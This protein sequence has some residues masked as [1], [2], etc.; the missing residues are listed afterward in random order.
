MKRQRVFQFSRNPACWSLHPSQGP[1][2]AMQSGHIPDVVLSRASAPVC[3]ALLFQR[4]QRLRSPQLPR[5]PAIPVTA[6]P[7]GLPVLGSPHR[8]RK[9][10]GNGIVLLVLFHDDQIVEGPQYHPRSLDG[11]RAGVRVISPILDGVRAGGQSQRRGVRAGNRKAALSCVQPTE[12]G[13]EAAHRWRPGPG[14]THGLHRGG[15][16]LA[17]PLVQ[18]PAEDDAVPA[19]P[20]GCS[21]SN[22]MARA[23][24]RVDGGLAAV[25]RRYYPRRCRPIGC[26]DRDG[27]MDAAVL[28]DRA[29]ARLCG[30][31]QLAGWPWPCAVRRGEAALLARAELS[32]A[33]A[34]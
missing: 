9:R 4:I 5:L 10:Q 25:C 16:L 22:A 28:A 17:A 21:A 30:D 19:I 18:W 1:R 11:Q 7:P 13:M 29:V 20:G 33:D 34:K 8:L 6:P 12:Y 27:G 2:C 24:I 23:R 26:C 14:E 3:P 31:V 15:I 32:G